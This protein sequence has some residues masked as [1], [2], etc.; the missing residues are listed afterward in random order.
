MNT[1]QKRKEVSSQLAL[2]LVMATIVTS[3]GAGLVV[4]HP[5]GLV[6]TILVPIVGV[7]I[8]VSG[9]F[10]LAMTWDVMKLILNE[11]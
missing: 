2:V 10:I 8:F 1:P 3:F 5:L 6:D 11:E 9:I 4:T 7:M